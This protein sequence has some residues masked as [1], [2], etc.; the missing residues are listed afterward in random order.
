MTETFA[1][2]DLLRKE[3][4]RQE[5]LE[6]MKQN[7]DDLDPETIVQTEIDPWMSRFEEHATVTEALESAMKHDFPYKGHPYWKFSNPHRF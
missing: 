2:R 4:S 3:T 1:K 7:F 5:L 6:V